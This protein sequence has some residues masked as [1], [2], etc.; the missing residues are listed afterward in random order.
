M[1][2]LNTYIVGYYRVYECYN[3][4]YYMDREFGGGVIEIKKEFAL[5]LIHGS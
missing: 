4:S 2:V 3:G 1:K 5:K